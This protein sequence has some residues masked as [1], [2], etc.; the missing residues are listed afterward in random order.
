MQGGVEMKYLNLASKNRNPTRL[1]FWRG[2]YEN[3][4]PPVIQAFPSSIVST[5]MEGI[6]GNGGGNQSGQKL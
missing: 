4:L 5:P 2:A 3:I 6:E 1:R